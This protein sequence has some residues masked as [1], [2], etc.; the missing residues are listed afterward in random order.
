[1]SRLASALYCG[2]VVHRRIKPVGHRLSYRVYYLLVDLDELP[3]LDGALRLFSHN[4]FNLLSL[5]DGDHGDGRG[6]SLRAHVERQLS[7]AGI[8]IGRG[9]IRLLAMPR[10]LGYVF[11]PISVYF[12]HREDGTPAAILYE[13]NNTFGQRHSYLARIDGN[14]TAAPLRHACGK[15][16]YVSPFID[17]AT[18]YRFATRPPGDSFALTIE[19]NDAEGPLLQA[20]L[21]ARRIELG[22]G[23]LL[24]AFVTHPLLTLK[25][26]GGIHWEALR[27]WLKGLR[28]R[29]RPAPPDRP[30]TIMPTGT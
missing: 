13:V 10:V 14:G 5:H 9:R 28:P 12:C 21:T 23:A 30:T 4:R 8:E 18:T 2:T 26:I 3:V 16:L 29:P 19:Q 6:G 20:S 15:Q 11:N 7:A 22:D 25:V 27:L 1:M 17:M 24:Q